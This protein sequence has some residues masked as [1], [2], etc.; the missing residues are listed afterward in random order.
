M[1]GSGVNDEDTRTSAGNSAHLLSNPLP[2]FQFLLLK[3][4]Q[5]DNLS[6]RIRSDGSR[7]FRGILGGTVGIP[8]PSFLVRR[9]ASDRLASSG[10]ISFVF[11]VH[12]GSWVVKGRRER[13]E[14]T[15]TSDEKKS[16]HFGIRSQIRFRPCFLTL[17]TLPTQIEG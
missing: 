17:T 9:P 2:P 7:R 8:T 1:T 10:I 11:S 4:F 12:G 3:W 6:V 13:T 15:P 14:L 16:V 5:A